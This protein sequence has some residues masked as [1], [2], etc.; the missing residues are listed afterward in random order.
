MSLEKQVDKEREI[1]EGKRA[2]E[3][4]KMCYIKA[5][6]RCDRIG[7]KKD[8]HVYYVLAQDTV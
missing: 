5:I 4:A 8:V 6:G 7:Q 2:S 3:W 1:E